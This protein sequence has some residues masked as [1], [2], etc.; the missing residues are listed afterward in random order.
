MA[1]KSQI[2]RTRRSESGVIRTRIANEERFGAGS[3]S[4]RRTF[5]RTLARLLLLSLRRPAASP[6][7]GPPF[8]GGLFGSSIR[9]PTAEEIRSPTAANDALSGR[10]KS[11]LSLG[12]SIKCRKANVNAKNRPRKS[13][14]SPSGRLQPQ[15]LHETKI[16]VTVAPHAQPWPKW[17]GI[18][19]STS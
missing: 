8:S 14:Q 12:P 4:F 10:R 11:Q 15:V 13:S 9:R 1:L 2:L 3:R 5:F 16:D 7:P 6:A 18:Q 19:A 17:H